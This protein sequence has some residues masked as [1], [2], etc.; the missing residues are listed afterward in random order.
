MAASSIRSQ[1]G[2]SNSRFC[3]CFFFAV[4][5]VLMASNGF[6]E[7]Q[8]LCRQVMKTGN[9]SC[10]PETCNS[11]CAAVMSLRGT[12]SCTQTFTNRFTCICTSP[13]S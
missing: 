1:M 8:E 9:G 3:W 10:D 6:G 12:G 5:L 2:N 4:M 11:Q 13:C 7:A